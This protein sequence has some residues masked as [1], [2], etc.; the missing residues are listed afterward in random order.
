LI[1]R[2]RVRGRPRPAKVASRTLIVGSVIVTSNDGWL[3]ECFCWD[4]LQPLR[5]IDTA[6][7]VDS[8][9]CRYGISE[10]FVEAVDQEIRDGVYSDYS[11]QQ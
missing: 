2:F 6:L 4:S 8:R 10:D 1:C 5:Q 7:L 9:V 11:M 3:F